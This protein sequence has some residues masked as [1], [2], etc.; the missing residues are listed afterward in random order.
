MAGNGCDDRPAA[1]YE[2]G[3]Q[4]WERLDEARTPDGTLLSFVRR[5]DEHRILI[6]TQVLMSTRMKGSEEDLARLGCERAAGLKSPCVLV[7]GLGFGFTLRAA[8]DLLPAR[9][10]VVVA[11][12]VPNVVEWNRG[13]VGELA[14]RPLDDPRVEVEIDDVRAI[15]RRG[16]ARFDAILLDV[17]NGPSAL[18]DATNVGLYADAGLACIRAALRPAGVLAVWSAAGDHQFEARLRRHGL[19][20]ETHRVRARGDRGGARHVVFVGRA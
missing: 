17:D 1:W 10:S 18:T 20:P 7:G 9:S 13:V 8:L 14:S 19:A 11:E 4:P 6:G 16:R 12:L 3:M 2:A 15:M 5:G